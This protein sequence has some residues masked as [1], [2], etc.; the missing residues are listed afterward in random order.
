MESLGARAKRALEERDAA[1]RELRVA[2]ETA[3]ESARR[4]AALLRA[5]A[6]MVRIRP[7][8]G[9][10]RR[11]IRPASPPGANAALLR[12]AQAMVRPCP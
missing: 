8:I 10:F 7:W 9:G 4:N 6:A 2:L 11:W 3:R 5:A 12:A 1:G